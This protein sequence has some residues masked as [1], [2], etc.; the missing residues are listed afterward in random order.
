[1]LDATLPPFPGF[2]PEAFRFLRQLRKNNDR[3][4]FKPR[5]GT[6]EDELMWPM[7]C[8]V[9]ELGRELPAR[10]VPLAGDPARALFRIYRDTRFSANKDPYK[11]YVA[12]YLSRSGDRKEDG[13]L[14]VHVG[15]DECF[16][17][18][19]FW[20][21]D[22][23]LVSRWRERLASA[24]GEFLDAVATLEEAGLEVRMQ[25]PLKRM[26]RGYEP[27]ADSPA[28]EYLKAKGLFAT[29][30]FTQEEAGSPELAA[31]IADTAVATLPLLRWGWALME[32]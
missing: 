7:Q 18:S 8:L 15:H 28:A 26:P 32:V 24:P 14:Y 17:G 21:S 22:K 20:N 5:K 31:T 25:D 6:Y 10:G 12:A 9:A 29:R 23:A 16:F 11:T 3:A 2:R 1:V 19:G 13:G 30:N 27:A 4:W